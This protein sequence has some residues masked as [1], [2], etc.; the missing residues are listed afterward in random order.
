MAEDV[1][2]NQGLLPV[3]PSSKGEYPTIDWG[4]LKGEW[5]YTFLW[6]RKFFWS[7]DNLTVLPCPPFILTEDLQSRIIVIFLGT[8]KEDLTIRGGFHSE[9]IKDIPPME[10]TLRI[11]L[12][13]TKIDKTVHHLQQYKVVD[14]EQEIEK[15]KYHRLLTFVRIPWHEL[16]T[17]CPPRA[18]FTVRATVQSEFFTFW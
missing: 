18:T 8:D 10:L 2:E 5:N 4:E 11:E 15:G 1:F 6:S 12:Q 7:R 13:L 17:S 14:I 3:D 16:S 9:T